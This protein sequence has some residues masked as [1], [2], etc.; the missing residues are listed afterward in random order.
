MSIQKSAEKVKAAVAKT[1][2]S[3][4]TTSSVSTHQCSQV[5]IPRL[6]CK[7]IHSFPKTLKVTVQR[8]ASAVSEDWSLEARH[9]HAYGAHVEPVT[10]PGA[11]LIP[12]RVKRWTLK[13]YYVVARKI[14]SMEKQAPASRK[15]EFTI[16]FKKETPNNGSWEE[17]LTS[18]EERHFRL[19][20]ITHLS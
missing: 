5:K 4:T 9:T 6:P 16:L 17:M 12:E 11:D 2:K 18:K 8:K 15:F 1:S 10:H 20:R 3:V 7:L 13:E 14:Q 19:G